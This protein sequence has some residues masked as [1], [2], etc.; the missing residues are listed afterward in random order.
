MQ[1]FQTVTMIKIAQNSAGQRLDNFLFKTLKGVPKSRVYRLIRKKE[2]R[3]NRSRATASTKLYLGDE[4]RL[5][6]IRLNPKEEQSTDTSL[7]LE[8]LIIF[9]NNELMVVNKPAGLAVHGGSS[10]K[11]GL[12]ES[13]RASRKNERSKERLELIH[14]LD[15]DTSG[16]L[17]ISKKRSHLVFLQDLLRKPGSIKK[18][19]TALVHGNWPES[20]I[21]IDKPLKTFSYQGRERWTKVSESGKN[22]KTTFRKLFGTEDFSLIEAFPKTGRTHQIR[23]HTLWARHPIVGDVRYGDKFKEGVMGLNLRMMLHATQISIPENTQVGKLDIECPLPEEF[24]M[25]IDKIVKNN[26]NNKIESISKLKS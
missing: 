20:L 6:P 13:L 18:R 16:C 4:V 21:D 25:T 12:I 14:R 23:V 5:P 9:E 26:K 2:I 10:V 3:V 22:A 17:M 7:D 1:T 24:T 8:S 15:K 19:Y 11:F